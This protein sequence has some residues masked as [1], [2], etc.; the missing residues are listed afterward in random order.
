MAH[1]IWQIGIPVIKDLTT[2]DMT[3]NS[4]AV[5]IPFATKPVVPQNLRVKVVRFVRRVVNVRLGAFEKEETVMVH[6]LGATVEM[7][8][9]CDVSS[10]LVVNQLLHS[11]S[12]SSIFDTEV[13]YLH[14]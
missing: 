1:G 10:T 2:H 4:P 9:R 5:L 7:E 8:K 3:T 14:H 12:T 6:Q 11:V 13:N